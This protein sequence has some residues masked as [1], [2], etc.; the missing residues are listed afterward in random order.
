MLISNPGLCDT[1][2]VYLTDL[3]GVGVG[4]LGSGISSSPSF[5]FDG[6]FDEIDDKKRLRTLAGSLFDILSGTVDA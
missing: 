4:L 1:L 3:R 5:A 2:A 6:S